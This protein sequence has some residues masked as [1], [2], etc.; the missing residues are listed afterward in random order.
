MIN[1][2]SDFMKYV[3]L[4]A[5]NIKFIIHSTF[6]AIFMTVLACKKP[7]KTH[8]NFPSTN[9]IEKNSAGLLDSS[10]YTEEYLESKISKGM[11]SEEVT[12]LLGKPYRDVE[13]MGSVRASYLLTPQKSRG[14]NLVGFTVV[15]KDG[16]VLDI[17]MNWM[18]TR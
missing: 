13:F 16:K 10:I 3:T 9:T 11:S 6:A 14:L 4:E 1:L 5:N 12:S 7:S 17:D 8:D 18:A 15:Y 2:L